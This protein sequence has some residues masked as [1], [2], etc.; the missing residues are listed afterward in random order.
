MIPSI[1]EGMT[2][3]L[4]MILNPF[5][6]HE[7]IIA[8]LEFS[9]SHED[10]KMSVKIACDVFVVYN[11]LLWE[12]ECHEPRDCRPIITGEWG[13]LPAVLNKVA[14]K[15]DP[16]TAS[17][18][19]SLEIERTSIDP[20]PLDEFFPVLAVLPAEVIGLGHLG[21]AHS[22]LDGA[23]VAREEIAHLLAPSM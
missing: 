12:C 7:I 18:A 19:N 6:W 11:S 23:W 1:M 17:A 15:C 8:T 22:V 2:E 9:T 5:G 13:V 10:W 16:L 21:A 14:W 4:E 3:R 20:G